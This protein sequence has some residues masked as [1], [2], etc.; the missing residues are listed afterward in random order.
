M[1]TVDTLYHEVGELKLR[2]MVAAFYR[3]VKTDALIGVMYPPE[4]WE[5]SEKR[6]A[7]FIVYR[8]GGPQTYLEERGHPRLRGRHMGFP[9]GVAERDQWLKLMG[10]SMLEVGVST[11]AAQIMI[12][13]FAQVADMMRNRIE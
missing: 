3:R 12:P 11:E 4:D 5:G 13:F 6:L 9:I 7:D 1:I 10:E 2:A 8:F